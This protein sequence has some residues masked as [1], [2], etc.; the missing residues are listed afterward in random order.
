MKTQHFF[1][2]GFD[3]VAARF[4]IDCVSERP[5][6]QVFQLVAHLQGQLDRQ[7]Q[8]AIPESAWPSPTSDAASGLKGQRNV[9]AAVR[10]EPV[11]AAGLTPAQQSVWLSPTSDA[12]N[13]LKNPGSDHVAAID[14][15]VRGGM[16]V[17][18]TGRPSHAV[19]DL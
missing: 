12:A 9:Y 10:D 15:M 13:G 5:Y 17:E 7:L 1:F 16:H 18:L 11:N 6:K 3:E 2:D 4:I 19:G 8:G 14:E